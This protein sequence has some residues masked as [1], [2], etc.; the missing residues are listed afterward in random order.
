MQK[1]YIVRLSKQERNVLREI[2]KKVKSWSELTPWAISWLRRIRH[3][4]PGKSGA[5]APPSR[6]SEVS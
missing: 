1:K 2:V 5:S 3:H 4:L 6:L